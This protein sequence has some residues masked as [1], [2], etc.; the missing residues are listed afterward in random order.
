MKRH[1]ILWSLL[2]AYLLVVGLWPAAATPV[3]VAAVGAFT[4][5]A[6]PAVLLLAAVVALVVSARRRPAHVPARRH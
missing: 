5:L 6:Q 1:P 3:N 2:A 4:V